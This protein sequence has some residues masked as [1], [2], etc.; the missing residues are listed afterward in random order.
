MLLARFLTRLVQVLGGGPAGADGS[1]EVLP[2]PQFSER[3]AVEATGD[4]D[5]LSSQV[6]AAVAAR[7]AGSAGPAPAYQ[8]ARSSACADWEQA[9]ARLERHSVELHQPWGLSLQPGRFLVH[10]HEARVFFITTD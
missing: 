5:C 4:G 8:P 1:P 9:E 3:S 10:V 6:E 7:P 2:S